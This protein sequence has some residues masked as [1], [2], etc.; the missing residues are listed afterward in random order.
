VA[1]QG[2][3][4]SVLTLV[5]TLRTAVSISPSRSVADSEDDAAIA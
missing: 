2:V 1:S 4:G 3:V 5:I